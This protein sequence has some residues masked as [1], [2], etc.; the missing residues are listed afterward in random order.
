MKK[1]YFTVTIDVL[2]VAYEFGCGTG[3]SF[4]LYLTDPQV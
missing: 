4:C 2:I 3:W 1:H